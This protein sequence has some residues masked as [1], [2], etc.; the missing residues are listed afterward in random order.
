[1]CWACELEVLA[2]DPNRMTVYKSGPF[3]VKIGDEEPPSYINDNGHELQLYICPRCGRYF[4][5]SS[6]IMF[7]ASPMCEEC[8]KLPIK[9]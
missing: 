1:M 4:Y 9:F 3:T 7:F 2:V 6:G 5:L 8:G